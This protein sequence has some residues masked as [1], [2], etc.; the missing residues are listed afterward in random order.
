MLLMMATYGLGAAEIVSLHLEDVDWKLAILRVRRP[1]TAVVIEL[2]LL[3]AIA[4]AL[5]SYLQAERPS[6][7]HSR[8]IFCRRKFHTVHSRVQLYVIA[9]SGMRVKLGSRK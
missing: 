2:P 9:S 5:A 8:Q 1:K 4:K 6:L 7:A 3:S